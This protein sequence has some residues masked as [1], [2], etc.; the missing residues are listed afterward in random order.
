MNFEEVIKNL[1]KKITDMKESQ[2][3]L[4]E[5]LLSMETSLNQSLKEMEDVNKGL[6]DLLVQKRVA[7]VKAPQG[8]TPNIA[9]TTTTT[10]AVG[11]AAPATGEQVS[12]DQIEKLLAG[13]L[14]SMGD[15]LSEKL[16]KMMKDMQAT[17]GPMRA[18]KMKEFQAA[19]DEEMI[20]L[21]SLYSHTEVKSNIAE[22][23]V[24]EKQ[25]K[26]VDSALEKLRKMRKG[27]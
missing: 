2:A 22:V 25:T 17:A 24:D 21:S 13:S 18:V 3:Q 1:S 15:K 6:K 26:G 5:G 19:A 16:M 20:D 9:V 4:H 8:P 12:A 27:K 10:E 7:K 11:Q 23:G 14:E